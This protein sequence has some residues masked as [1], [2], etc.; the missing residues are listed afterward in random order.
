MIYFQFYPAHVDSKKP[1]GTV[2]LDEFVNAIRNPSDKIKEVFRQIANAASV[3]DLKLKDSL[4]QNNLYYFTPCVYTDCKGRGYANIDYFNGVAVLDFDKIDNAETLRDYIFDN[5]NCVICAYVSPSK[6]GAK[7]LVKIPKVSTTDEFKEYF[8]GLGCEF[9]KWKGWDGTAQ[10]CVLPLFLSIDSNIRY[11][12]DAEE[13]TQR[14]KTLDS[15]KES[16]APPVKIETTDADKRRVMENIKKAIDLITD[17]G[18]PQVRAAAVSLGG[19]VASGYIDRFEAESF[20]FGLVRSNAYL[21]KGP[22]GY[23]KTAKTAIEIGSRSQLILTK[24]P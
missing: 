15:F 1:I 4:K 3:G 19:Y 10:N 8:Y 22:D 6:R 20:I 5:Y 21:S 11:R 23:I 18:H 7:F 9:E 17:N 13:W 2:S 16:T 12:T 14:G 24:L